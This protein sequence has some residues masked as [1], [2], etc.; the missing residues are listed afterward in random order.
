M[1]RRVVKKNNKI[2]VLKKRLCHLSSIIHSTG[3]EIAHS[4]QRKPPIAWTPSMLVLGSGSQP[5]LAGTL[6][7]PSQ[8]T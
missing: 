7:T 5:G 6:G 4:N 8:T 1:P 3:W 2:I